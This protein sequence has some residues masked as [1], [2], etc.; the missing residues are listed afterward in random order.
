MLPLN[1]DGGNR[2]QKDNSAKEPPAQEPKPD[3]SDSP[4]V[5][6]L[7]RTAGLNK[8]KHYYSTFSKIY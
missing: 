1:Q 8:P 6:G 3:G 2:R 5:G 7:Q 4:E